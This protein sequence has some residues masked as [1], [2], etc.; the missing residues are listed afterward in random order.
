VLKEI[1]IIHLVATKH[2]LGQALRQPQPSSARANFDH[3]SEPVECMVVAEVIGHRVDEGARL[4]D[5]FPTFGSLVPDKV[6]GAG[7]AGRV[8][9]RRQRCWP[10]IGQERRVVDARDDAPRG[11]GTH[12]ALSAEVNTVYDVSFV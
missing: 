10:E 6:S 5:Q 11:V 3:R 7:S 8:Y 12:A 9:D 4:A 2:S 1:V